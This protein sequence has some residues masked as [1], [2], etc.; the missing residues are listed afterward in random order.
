MGTREWEELF[1]E[2]RLEEDAEGPYNPGLYEASCVIWRVLP[3]MVLSTGEKSYVH[4][5]GYLII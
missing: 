1:I 5:D 2:V 3:L 4:N